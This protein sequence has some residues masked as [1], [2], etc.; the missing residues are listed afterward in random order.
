MNSL[1]LLVVPLLLV[2]LILCL[3]SV[4]LQ[5]SAVSYRPDNIDA[6]GGNANQ[7][8]FM[9]IANSSIEQSQI[10]YSTVSSVVS[11]VSERIDLLNQHFAAGY[12][13][14]RSSLT[15]INNVDFEDSYYLQP[16]TLLALGQFESSPNVFA[17]SFDQRIES[18]KKHPWIED[19]RVDWKILP[20]R[21]KVSITEA[22]PWIVA[23][24]SGHSWLLSRQRKLLSPLAVLP[25]KS[26]VELSS[27]LARIDGLA[28]TPGVANYLSSENARL[29]YA[30]KM[31]ALLEMG[32]VLSHKVDRYTLTSDGS[33]LIRPRPPARIPNIRLNVHTLEEAHLVAA[34][35]G[36]VLE[37]L[38]RR[39][40]SAR[41][42]D[43]RFQPQVIV[44]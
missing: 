42:I 40:E 17:L 34:Q 15:E 5:R 32:A 43:L 23:E 20:I 8:S 9:A 14:L 25:N 26:L 7:S 24:Y 13:M 33:L 21:L 36:S 1:K 10:I 11:Q 22:E 30:T 35:L 39:G 38:G 6:I 27:E 3:G 19:V 31:V 37:D 29:E 12:S 18:I 2:V 41:E 44:R 28:E 4:Y 16:K